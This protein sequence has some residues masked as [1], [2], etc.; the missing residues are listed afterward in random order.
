MTKNSLLLLIAILSML[1]FGCS[2]EFEREENNLDVGQQQLSSVVTDST[3]GF[4]VKIHD[5]TLCFDS[6]KDVLTALDVLHKM[7]LVERR[8]WETSVGFISAQTLLENLKSKIEVMDDTED[9]K[10]LIQ[11]NK[12]LILESPNN[13]YGIQSRIY[14]YYPYITGKN[15]LFVSESVWCKIFDGK[16]Y[17][18]NDFDREGYLRMC[19]LSDNN[20]LAG[21]KVKSIIVDFNWDA[22]QL[23]SYHLDETV[24]DTYIELHQFN[25][26]EHTPDKRSIFEMQLVNNFTTRA[27]KYR[28]TYNQYY[29]D[30]YYNGSCS[31][32]NPDSYSITYAGKT[33]PFLLVSDRHYR[34][35]L[36]YSTYLNDYPFANPNW[37]SQSI[38][39]ELITTAIWYEYTGSVDVS[40]NFQAQ[41]K[42]LLF[43][44]VNWDGTIVWFNNV[45]A[46]IELGK[47]VYYRSGIINLNAGPMQGNFIDK[48]ENGSAQDY[49][50]VYS[51]P[52]YL[53][54]D[55]PP[56]KFKG[57]VSGR[58]SS[59]FC[60]EEYNFNFTF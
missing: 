7:P 22:K 59:R 41:K 56:V 3:L 60:P 1:I 5:N 51:T 14:G 11:E 17:S 23:K 54:E 24:T 31:Y 13:S 35:N 52:V 48:N 6:A 20:D 10:K 39:Y 27:E 37:D 38:S 49:S 21:S 42:N 55:I 15:G 53:Y 43:Q 44:W 40:C 33:Y 2:K 26:T 46:D 30:V 25:F 34:I 18:T 58:L 28:S 16:L 36:P 47:Y 12:E 29:L 19:K 57:C 45:T 8:K 9:F 4:V 50:V 32:C